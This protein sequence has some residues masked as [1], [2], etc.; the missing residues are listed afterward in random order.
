[1][2]SNNPG[3]PADPVGEHPEEPAKPKAEPAGIE[4]GKNVLAESNDPSPGKTSTAA[5]QPRPKKTADRETSAASP[6]APQ[7]TS[8]SGVEANDQGG[9]LAGGAPC[10]KEGQAVPAEPEPAPAVRPKPE[11]KV[12]EPEDQSDSVKHE[13]CDPYERNEEWN[14]LAA[15][16]RGKLHAHKGMWREDAYGIDWIDDWTIIAVSDGAGSAELSRI[17]ARAACDESVASLRSLVAGWHLKTNEQGR[18]PEADLIRLRTFLVESARK[19]QEGILRAAQARH[20]SP[21]KMHATLLLVVHVP[22][23]E[24]E[25]VGAIQIGD[26]AVGILDDDGTCTLLGVPDHGEYSSETRFLTT[27]NIEREFER[28]VLFSFKRRIRCVGVMCDGV[29]DDFFPE[30]KRLVELFLGNPIEGMRTKDDGPVL[31]VMHQVVKEPRGGEALL[32]W[33]R[34]EKKASSDDRTLVLMYRRERT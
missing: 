5:K 11:W 12:L 30:E 8:K 10:T 3:V 34:Y 33:L 14:I 21:R 7:A 15:S 32:E 25:L 9:G 20:C 26:G 6:A 24:E 22:L 29:S 18:P 19:A 17:G 4:E 16:V 28:R 2:N 13:I 1:M 31:G 27:P 23:G